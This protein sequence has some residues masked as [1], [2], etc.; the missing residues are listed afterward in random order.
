[1]GYIIDGLMDKKPSRYTTYFYQFLNLCKGLTVGSS[2]LYS[3]RTSGAS[4]MNSSS[5]RSFVFYQGDKLITLKHDDRH[6][7]VFRTPDLPLAEQR[8]AGGEAY[9]LFATD[10]K[11]SVLSV[12][13]TDKGEYHA[14]SA[15]GHDPKLPSSLTLLGFNGEAFA[16]VS[17]GYALGN[18]YRSFNP[19]M[20][21]FI[22][23][24]RLSP[25]GKGGINAYCYCSCDPVNNV[26]PSGQMK[27]ML[28]PSAQ[29]SQ[30][31]TSITSINEPDIFSRI[32]RYLD[33]RSAG[34]FSRANKHLYRM[35]RPAFQKIER[36]LGH[37]GQLV[38]AALEGT[39]GPA[40]GHSHELLV[41]RPDITLPPQSRPDG[42][43][44]QLIRDIQ[45]SR[46]FREAQRTRLPSSDTSSE[47][48]SDDE[49]S[50]INAGIRKALN[51]PQL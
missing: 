30:P 22:S 8:V 23:P 7:A 4:I 19:A 2:V 44:D 29:I 26:D 40:L 41:K 15:Y 46:K 14:Y 25:F 13:E 18:G 35:T 9:G 3:L 32:V 38:D 11:A 31:A 49:I 27:R 48:D 37:P 20:M 50:R 6:R 42:A 5:S 51:G 17:G 45:A 33:L 1:M 12:Q 24:D 10:A 36:S 43:R 16:L 28:H 21:R 34:A 39:V 47:S